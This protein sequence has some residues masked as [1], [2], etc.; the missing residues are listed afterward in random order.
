[1]QRAILCLSKVVR[2]KPVSFLYFYQLKNG[3]L[4]SVYDNVYTRCST[5][6]VQSVVRYAILRKPQD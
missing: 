3:K 2:Q 4:I 6:F 1:M 5:S